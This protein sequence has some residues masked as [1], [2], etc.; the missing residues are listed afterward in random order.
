LH[1]AIALSGLPSQFLSNA[2]AKTQPANNADF[3]NI[4]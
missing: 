4:P 3:L 1:A 2:A